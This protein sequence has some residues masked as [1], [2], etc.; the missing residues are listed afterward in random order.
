MRAAALALAAFLLL[1]ASA[2]G[3]GGH[4]SS[5]AERRAVTQYINEV[6]VVERQ[7]NARIVR[8]SL[9]YRRFSTSP[10][11]LAREH[12]QFSAAADSFAAL[13]R[14]LARVRAPALALRL[15]ARLLA[16]IDAETS[17]ARELAVFTTFLPTFRST[18]APLPAANARLTTGLTHVATPKPKR[19]RRS[20]LKQ[21]RAAYLRAVA[22]SAAQQAAVVS[23]YTSTVAAIERRLAAL[24][25]PAVLAP[26]YRTQLQTLGRVRA[27]GDE[28]AA[29][30]RTG[31]FGRVAT[32]DRQF[33]AAA[34]AT[35]SLVAQ[36]AQIAAIRAYDAQVKRIST[37]AGQVERERERLQKS[38][39]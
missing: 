18:L 27:V 12:R 10:A 34:L 4:S 2:C 33:R 38:L 32:L 21:A 31:K 16:L 13:R 39:S 24:H 14:R 28:L 22:A 7:L 11:A 29:A 1:V 20:K 30:L 8:A 15:R 26:T 17:V 19:V 9:A 5:K 36:R 35:S 3:G 23:A 25:P 37:L 6:N